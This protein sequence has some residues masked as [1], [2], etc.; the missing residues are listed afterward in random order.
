MNQS[1]LLVDDDPNFLSL[2]SDYLDFKGLQ[3][4]TA[5]SIESGWQSYS[6][7]NPDVVVS[8]IAMQS[9]DCGYRLFHRVREQNSS[10]PFIFLSSQLNVPSK[11]ENAMKLNA[12]A[13]FGKPFE[14]E[15]LLAAIEKLLQM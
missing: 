14:P 4:F 2:V 3:V 5:E 15:E 10:Q 13:Y 8:G 9:T 12:D 7:I 6:E 11:K 1:I